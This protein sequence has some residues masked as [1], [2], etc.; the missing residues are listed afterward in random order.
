MCRLIIGLGALLTLLVACGDSSTDDSSGDSSDR[1]VLVDLN[2]IVVEVDVSGATHVLG[3]VDYPTA[4][5]AGG[6]HFFAWQACGFYDQP[7]IDEVAVHSL[8]HGAVWVTYRSE[9]DV[10][11][12][13]DIAVVSVS[14]DH[15]LV[16]PYESQSSPLVLT[17]WE[18]Q[19]EVTTWEDP[20]VAAFLDRYLGRKSPTAPEAGVSCSGAIG[21]PPSDPTAGYDETVAAILA[22]G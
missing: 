19:L 21:E 5:P 7:L 3:E 16:S 13:G 17:A 14:E 18:R 2:E 20:A 11:T 6:D 22:E 10:E 4:P 15:L 12:L 8:E 1:P 9:I